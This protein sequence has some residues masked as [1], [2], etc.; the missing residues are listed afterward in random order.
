MFNVLFLRCG[1]LTAIFATVSLVLM[2]C[3]SF[4]STATSSS[5]RM[6]RSA[7]VGAA[8]AG[9]VVL[10]GEVHDNV[11][12]HAL[13]L[14]LVREIIASGA[15]PA[16]VFEQF[17]REQ[18]VDIDRFR[19]DTLSAS[20]TTAG[21]FVKAANVSRAGRNTWQWALY[22]PLIQIALDYKL[23]IIAA[24]LSRADAMRVTSLDAERVFDVMTTIERRT[25]ANGHIDASLL[26]VQQQEVDIGHC[27]LISPEALAPM[28]RAQI[29]R[30]AVMAASVSNAIKTD[31]TLRESRGALLFAGNG[32]TRRDI[33]VSQWLSRDVPRLTVG[34]LE[35]N[36]A[37]QKQITPNN[38]FDEVFNAPPQLRADPCDTLRK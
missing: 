17:D 14:Q 22:E 26:A 28:A 19:S 25:L 1:T 13:R 32:H 3:A 8:R 4:V 37:F 27:R 30:D 6:H 2:G 34:F 5:D 35:S 20:S 16:F 7:V 36:G 38:L 18:Q 12:L 21:E 29:V 24:N 10:L 23:P 15:R 9:H 31:K 11:A 33:G